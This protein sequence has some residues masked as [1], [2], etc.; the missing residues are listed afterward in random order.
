MTTIESRIEN[1]LQPCDWIN[2]FK[3]YHP[4]RSVSLHVFV[5]IVGCIP[6][7]IHELW[8][9]YIHKQGFKSYE[10]LWAISFLHV[11]AINDDTQAGLWGMSDNAYFT[12]VWELLHIL[13]DV[14]DEVD[15]HFYFALP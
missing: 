12:P 7:V 14:I 15:F 6:E 8:I 11:Y 9:K 10:L 4:T 3:K 2:V 13:Y 1:P 5:S